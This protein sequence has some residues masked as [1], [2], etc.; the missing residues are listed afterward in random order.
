[1]KNARK[2]FVVFMLTL[3]IC[4]MMTSGVHIKAKADSFG[5]SY[6]DPQIYTRET[7]YMITDDGINSQPM[8]RITTS[9]Y[10]YYPLEMRNHFAYV[11]VV[12]TLDVAEVNDGYQQFYLYNGVNTNAGL[13][14]SKTYEHASGSLNTN[15]ATAVVS[16]QVALNT[17]LNND[18]VIRYSASGNN[19]DTWLNKNLTVT[20]NYSG[21]VENGYDGRIYF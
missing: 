2:I 15:Y 3:S 21:P 16:I 14:G 12:I 18:I 1:M 19:A 5:S 13:L 8:D 11:T 10:T 20:L 7:E 9:D 6:S 17:F 4:L